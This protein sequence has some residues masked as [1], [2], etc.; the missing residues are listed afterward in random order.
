MIYWR[1]WFLVVLGFEVLSVRRFSIFFHLKLPLT[2]LCT[3]NLQVSVVDV[4]VELLGVLGIKHDLFLH[5][6]IV[7]YYYSI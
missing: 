6:V 1:V 5:L 3:Q 7:S 2:V 4:A